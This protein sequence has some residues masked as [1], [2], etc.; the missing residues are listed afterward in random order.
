MAKA[1]KK[2]RSSQSRA[3]GPDYKNA[4]NKDQDEQ[5]RTQKILPV[6]EKL[7]APDLTDRSMAIS[8]INVMS[9]DAKLR[10]LLLKERLLKVVLEK[11]IKDT[12]EEISSE[13]FGLLRNLC[14][15]EGYDVAVYLWRQ[16]VL[17]AIEESLNK[18]AKGFEAIA[19]LASNNSA[20][21]TK[22]TKQQVTTM[23]EFTEN[24]LGLISS[25]AGSSEDIFNSVSARLVPG[26]GQF[27]ISVISYARSTLTST[28]N[29]AVSPSL[30]NAVCEV[31]YVLSED[32]PE[33]IESVSDYP[34]DEILNDF[35]ADKKY[36][37]LPS[38]VYVNG[39]KYNILLHRLSSK[40]KT[41][42]TNDPDNDNFNDH[43]TTNSIL[44]EIQKS[45]IGVIK[46][47]E[48]EQAIKDMEPVSTDASM[49]EVNKQF[50]K[51]IKARSLIESV[52]V[53]MEIITAVAETIS[54]DPRDLADI[55]AANVS[56]S[57]EIAEEDE[58]MMVDND[59]DD[60]YISRAVAVKDD[61]LIDSS[62]FDRDE[63]ANDESMDSV[64]S[65]LQTEALPLIIKFLHIPVFQ[66]RAMAALNNIS[67][68][69]FTKAS[70]SATWKS[71]A[72]E[73][74][75]N[76][77]PHATLPNQSYAEIEVLNS[78]VGVLWAVAST[79]KGEV[80]I[81]GEAINFLISQ[82]GNL[83]S[84]FPA[85]ESSEYFIKVVGLLAQLAKAPGKQDV[86]IAVTKFFI[87]TL[88]TAVNTSVKDTS[89]A[90]TPKVAID[91]LYAIFD[92]FGDSSYEYDQPIY[93]EGGL[94]S[95][96]ASMLSPL[97]KYFK[98]VDRTKEALLRARGDETVLNLA[99]FID[100]KKQERQ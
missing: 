65:C 67:W 46:C 86:T 2:S 44:L 32:N 3:K 93:V 6:M 74:W 40:N 8:A 73:L 27:L 42:N 51:N 64:L 84:L 43:T 94:N 9:E 18:S 80:P 85:E 87:E 15:E 99:R 77:L 66:S 52:Q 83:P 34:F 45:L 55:E 56:E 37:P 75:T 69:M 82:T 81:S 63:S 21:D 88:T 76:I 72:Q 26:L 98:R 4:R 58:A 35:L 68:S 7:V 12:N 39:L 49:A 78:A 62:V 14:I 91:I 30:F 36:Y 92:V 53:A 11:S 19:S 5:I 79:F 24:V 17:T 60:L 95:K 1:K 20:D 48:I 97:R 33:F 23:F 96:L 90:L 50:Q 16:Q 54:V 22:Y 29:I 13:A 59:D 71:N 100:Y 57:G 10:T 47:I 25:L 31:L 61:D 28:S 70:E 89:A 38:L 41:N